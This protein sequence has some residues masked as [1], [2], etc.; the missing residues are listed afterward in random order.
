MKKVFVMLSVIGGI[1]ILGA[2]G[3][4]D[5]SNGEHMFTTLLAGIVFV[6][7]GIV[8]D[9][10]YRHYQSSKLIDKKIKK[11]RAGI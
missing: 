10:Y 9:W 5:T 1:F 4:A 11:L 3:M 8:G 6:A 7:C 2:A